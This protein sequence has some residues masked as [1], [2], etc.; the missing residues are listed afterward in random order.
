MAIIIGTSG[1]DTLKGTSDY[2]DNYDTLTGGGGNDIFFYGGLNYINTITDFGGVGKGTN[3]TAAVIA[4]VDTL[5]FQSYSGF[6]AQNLLLT[7][8]GTSLSISFQGFGNT[9]F[10]LENFALS[11]L[12]NLSKSTGATVD[13]GNIL[14]YGQTTITDSFDVFDANST[15]STVFKKNTVTFLNDL[16]NNVSGFD[17]SNDV[18]NGQ[19]GDDIIEGLSGNDILRGG[20]GNNTLNGGVG[21]DTFYADSPSSNNLLNGGDGNDFLDISGSDKYYSYAP[22]YDDRSLGNNTLNGGAGDDTL[23]ASGSFGDN[24]LDGG[25]GNDSLSISGNQRGEE[26][27]AFNSRSDGDNILNGGAGDDTLSASG[28]NGDNLLFGGDGNDFLDISGFI[29][30][31]FDSSYNSRSS[32]KNLLSGGDGNDTLTASGATGN[33]T[34]NGGNGDDSL[35]GGGGKDSLTGGGGKDKFVY[36]GLSN[37]TTNSGR[38]TDTINTGTYTIADFTGVGK[39]TNPTAAV[40]AEVDTLIF[41]DNSGFTADNLLLTQ[42]GTS[43]SIRFQGYGDTRFILENFALENLDNLTKSTGATVDLGNILFYGQTTITDSFDVFDA[44]STQSTVFKK[45][46]VTFLNDLDNNVS[47]FDN[48]NDVINGQ[49]GDDIIEGLSGNDILRGGDGNDTLN[50][51]DGND[52]LNSGI[53]NNTLNGGNGDDSLN[54]YSLSTLV[55]QTVDGGTGNDTLSLSYSSATTGITSTFNPTTNIG[56]ISTTADTTVFSYKNIEQLNI[57]GTDYDDYLVGSNGNDTLRSGNGNDT[58]DGGAGEDLLDIS[59][60][61]GNHLLNG[62]DGND[63]LRALSSFYDEFG[64]YVERR[65][66]GDNTLNGGAGNDTLDISGSADDNLL[67]GGD[68]N[69]F[70]SAIY[71]TTSGDNTLK[72]G[73]GDDTLDIFGSTGNNLLY[74]GDGNDS[75]IASL[76]SGNNTLEGGNGDDT[77][78]GGDGDGD[79]ILIGGKGNDWLYGKG[80][81]YTIADFTGVGKGTNPTAAVIAEVDT[82]IFQDNSG[83]TAKN[84]LLTQNGTSLSIRFQGYGDTRFI[85]ENFALENLD[86]LTKST[87]ATVDL[88]NILFYGQTTITD[89]FDVFDANSTQS[90][91]FKKNTVTFLNDLDNNV[92]GFDNSNDV[93]NGQGGDDI[94]E[95]LSGNDILRGGDGNDTLNG[96]DG[97]DT[98]NSGIGNNTLNGGN[99][100]DSLNFYSL[101]T[102]V[103]QTVDGGTGND[104]LSLSYSSATTGITSTFNPTTNIGAISTTADTTVFSY[105]NIE[106]L[107]ITGTDY[108]DYLVGSNGNDT[109]RSGNGN[110]TI[111]GGAGED[112][113]DISFSIG[114]HLLNGGDGNDFLQALSSFYDEFGNYVRSSSLGNNTLN[115]GAGNDILYV[116]SSADDNLLDG[117]DGNDF[118]Y[119]PFFSDNNTL[120]G[121]VGNDTLNVNSS[122]GNNLL[123]GGDGNDSLIASG[124]SGN[125]T[126]EGGN[127]DDTLT[128]GNGDAIII[129]GKGNDWLYGEGGTDTFVFNSFDEG[130][131]LIRDFGSINEPNELIQVSA[132]GFGGGL[133]AGVLQ[134]S[135]FTLGESATTSKE[136]FIYNST[137]G[138]L[139][140]DQDGSA[141]AFTQVQFAGLFPGLSLTNNNFVVV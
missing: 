72:G 9:G 47:G 116:E 120:N 108:D 101:S 24:L 117:G 124:A 82:V 98:L 122:T 93:I 112:L 23:N 46:T 27:G 121:G 76:T 137:T 115:G 37:D 71:S 11:N 42:N 96:G 139:F 33:N 28:S 87:G 67:D 136:R 59:F 80:G 125:N 109:L 69:D 15:Q 138:A 1:N 50:G 107:N 13:L 128:G 100:D 97:N 94:I 102:L 31:Y 134:A 32:G 114:N 141:G 48:S 99:G 44:N 66:S 49:G 91:V 77:L 52:T 29:Y 36:K 51:G 43:L 132:A 60:S 64:N 22:D 17:N 19:G 5:S 74:G 38:I 20:A 7:Q 140:F 68:G 89:S 4:E 34:L 16:S 62:G 53:G 40:I 10:I 106:Q 83:F 92:S 63:S 61:I 85:L 6:T 110:D 86:N 8:N 130:L 21:D 113:L 73:N 111:D 12:D 14:F 131:D 118:L 39:G 70:L 45:N 78:R 103:T 95:G 26:Y 2:Y 90:T 88:G 41:Q 129:G 104:T 105:K 56:A 54:F 127:G 3:P 119:T 30:R 79:A 58:I 55:T 57:T 25:D 81:T 75:L 18:I 135:Q 133:S 126:L 35:T 84:L 65:T 123:D